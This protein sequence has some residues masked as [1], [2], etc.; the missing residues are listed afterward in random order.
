MTAERRQIPTAAGYSIDR[1][2]QV[3]RVEGGHAARVPADTAGRVTLH[4]GRSCQVLSCSDLLAVV[5]PET[6]TE[7]PA[8]K[9]TR[10]RSRR[11]TVE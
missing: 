6:A 4:V 8:K 7:K 10:R 5:W 3:Y 11:D 2:G 9:A 1:S